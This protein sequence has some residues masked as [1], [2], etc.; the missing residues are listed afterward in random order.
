M[1]KLIPKRLD[2]ELESMLAIGV[3]EMSWDDLD[4]AHYA[5]P[6]VEQVR[7]YR[8]KVRKLVDDFIMRATIQL[9]IGW[10]DPMWVV[11]M[12]IEHERIHL[13]TSSVLIRQLPIHRVRSNERFVECED[14]GNVAPENRLLPVKGRSLR[15][16]KDRD[17]RQQQ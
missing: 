14:R 10:D 3:D 16:G 13:E 2:P 6:S 4:E 11:M 5:W 8:D 15:L 12:G 1:A 7:A 9:P 17:D